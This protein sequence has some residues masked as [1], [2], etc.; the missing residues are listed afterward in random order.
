[1]YSS[2]IC[3]GLGFV[4]VFVLLVKNEGKDAV[5]GVLLGG[6]DRKGGTGGTTVA[7]LCTPSARAAPRRPVF[8]DVFVRLL[9]AAFGVLSGGNDRK[10]GTGGT[11]VAT[12]CTSSAVLTPKSTERAFAVLPKT[13]GSKERTFILSS[14]MKFIDMDTSKVK[15]T[16]NPFADLARLAQGDIAMML[17][18][19]LCS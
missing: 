13:S 14:K 15:T 2:K 12:L 8:V 4:L 1:M 9:D 11:T 3:S 5:V 16:A 17:F 7:M 19:S 18:S 6:N 10:G